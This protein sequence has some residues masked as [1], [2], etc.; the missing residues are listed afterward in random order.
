LW[1]FIPVIPTTQ[2]VK[3]GGS[4][5]KASLG[6]STRPYQKKNKAKVLGVFKW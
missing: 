5:F 2:E 3:I 1:W 4:Q 6:K